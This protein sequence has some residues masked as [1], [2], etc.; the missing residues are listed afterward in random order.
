MFDRD[1]GTAAQCAAATEAVVTELVILCENEA[2]GRDI[3]VRKFHRI[4]QHIGALCEKFVICIRVMIG[5]HDKVHT[6]KLQLISS[7]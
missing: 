5:T 7:G 2:Q 1:S 6:L 4:F 3:R